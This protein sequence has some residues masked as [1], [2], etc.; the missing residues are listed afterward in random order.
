MI[1]SKVVS[2]EEIAKCAGM[3][4]NIEKESEW[5]IIQP[6][7][8]IYRIYKEDG[9]LLCAIQRQAMDPVL[10]ELAV[11]C[12]REVG[13]QISTNR[14]YA[15][16]I[17]RREQR[18]HYQRGAPA[19]TGVIGYIDSA[20]SKF[21]C[22]LTQYS[23]NHFTKYQKGLPFIKQMDTLMQ[24]LVPEQH[25]IQKEAASQAV[26]H[27]GQA[28]TIEGTAFSTV[29]VNKDFRTALHVDSGDYRQGFGTIAVVSEGISGGWLLFPQYRVAIVLASGDFAA[30]DVHEWHCNTPITK[31]TDKGYRLSFIA[32]FKERLMKCSTMNRRLA[33]VSQTYKSS[34]LLHDIFGRSVPKQPL[35]DPRWWKMEDERYLVIYRGKRY[36]FT[37]KSTNKV[38]QNLWPA[39]EYVHQK[40]NG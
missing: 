15:A 40:R 17:V 25:A 23:R 37:E 12:Y 8:T 36:T 2:D 11:E 24:E 9:T 39:W 27:E 31:H 6:S 7:H 26:D 16:G 1:V 19:Q 5:Q 30:M 3:H 13:E 33:M 4:C 32:Y 34:D 28:L 21:P 14:G 20:N 29:T 38:I 22:R 35:S 10:C 18:V